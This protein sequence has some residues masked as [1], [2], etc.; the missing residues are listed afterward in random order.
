MLGKLPD[1]IDKAFFI[2]YFLPAAILVGG[3]ELCL[4]AFGV[5]PAFL[6]VEKISDFFDAVVLIAAVWLLAILLLALNRTLLRLME[7]YVH[8]F[9]F[10]LMEFWK[11]TA[12]R[13]DVKPVLDL[14]AEID[15]AAQYGRPAPDYPS[16]HS[17]RL[18]RA[19]EDYPHAQEHVLATRFGNVFRALEVHSAVIYGLDAIPAWP[20]LESVIP[21]SF[22][23]L[24]DEAKA[25]L[26]FAVNTFYAGL[27]ILG[28]Y[29]GLAAWSQEL[30]AW[31]L[32]PLA[33][34]VA[35]IARHMSLDALHQY[36]DYVKAS[37]DLYRP[38]L[39]NRL[40]L[41]LPDNAKD[42]IRMWTLVSQYLIYRHH[43]TYA[44]LD[45]FRRKG[46]NGAG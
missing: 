34:L 2:G 38:E 26:D 18:R 1:L 6:A 7:G 32:P 17:E 28:L 41:S 36:G 11:R 25:Q 9:P 40:G 4:H 12:F 19:A 21:E 3:I 31:W 24:I 13:Y 10:T 30:P 42:E 29:G 45:E 20:R 46:E 33:L 39:A 8:V 35:I 43:G 44:A 15:A 27:V 22:S 5:L 23:K 14:Q 16:D 37:F